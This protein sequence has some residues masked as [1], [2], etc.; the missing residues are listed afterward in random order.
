MG[1]MNTVG[2]GSNAFLPNQLTMPP[3]HQDPAAGGY[4]QMNRLQYVQYE[5]IKT[6]LKEEYDKRVNFLH[7][8]IEKRQA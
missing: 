6:E 8:R 7:K 1:V 2:Y 3:I 5:C 4:T